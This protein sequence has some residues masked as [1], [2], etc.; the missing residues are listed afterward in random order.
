MGK[1]VEARPPLD[2][3]LSGTW[4]ALRPVFP[5][6]F[7]FLY[8]LA[9]D[10]ANFGWRY[11]GSVLT[12]E[13]YV[14]QLWPGVLCQFL[15]VARKSNRPIG[16][17]VAYNADLHLGRTYVGGVSIPQVQRSGLM[18]EAFRLM[19]NYL[20]ATWEIR[21]LYFEFAEYNLAQF[22]SGLSRWLR[23]E[24]RLKGHVYF[25]GRY[26]DQYIY[27]LD[28]TIEPAAIRLR[29]DSTSVD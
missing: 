5:R 29:E 25:D 10:E 2:T 1:G 27:S 22:A 4:V 14:A 12:R 3:I 20:R 16:L 17:V 11:G 26:W 18:N 8:D 21:K 9:M 15:V 24:A 19:I 28:T 23:M 13:A 7:D 6:D